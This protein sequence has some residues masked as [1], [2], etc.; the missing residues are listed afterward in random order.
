MG[1]WAEGFDALW[2]SLGVTL[3]A[4][5]VI[6]LVGV[7]LAYVMSHARF[8]GKSLIEAVLVLPL[9][10]PPTVVGYVLIVMLGARGVLGQY[11]NGWTGYSIMFRPEGAV[12]AAAAVALPMFYLPAR[13]AFAGV[14]RAYEEAG[15]SLGA[16][17]GRVFWRITMPLAMRGLVSGLVLAFARGLGEF[18]ATL[19]VF[20]WQPGR[21]TLPIVIYAKYEQG[22]LAGAFP[23]AVMLTVLSLVLVGVY[24]QSG[25][26]VQRRS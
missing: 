3:G 17:R 18:G 10:L 5:A 15:R 26:G 21:Q 6:C 11:L 19:M 13:S 16:S 14:D 8:R 23:A 22:D 7:P 12:L 4:V 9:V 1:D 2:L 25:L 20:G 24:N